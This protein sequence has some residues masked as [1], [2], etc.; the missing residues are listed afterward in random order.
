MNYNPDSKG[1]RLATTWPKDTFERTWW[2]DRRGKR[3]AERMYRARNFLALI[4][5]NI[6]R[7]STNFLAGPDKTMTLAECDEWLEYIQK[8]WDVESSNRGGSTKWGDSRSYA[9][10]LMSLPPHARLGIA[11]SLKK[12]MQLKWK[13]R[14]WVKEG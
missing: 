6:H 13:P 8:A 4:Q 7:G 14:L 3:T 10:D 9:P 12:A 2:G 1:N 11:H 5:F